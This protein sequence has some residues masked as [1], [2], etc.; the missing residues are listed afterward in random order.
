VY[1]AHRKGRKAEID[2]AVIQREG[3]IR[4]TGLSIGSLHSRAALK[5]AEPG[6]VS[7]A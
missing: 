3:K 1:I 6:A 2:N 7:N 4:V 5:R